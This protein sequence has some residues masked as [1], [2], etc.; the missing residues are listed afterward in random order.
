[1]SANRPD[2]SDANVFAG[3]ERIRDAYRDAGVARQYVHN[4]FEQPLGRLL[5]RRQVRTI[6]ELLAARRPHDVLEIA[7]GPARVTADV[8]AAWPAGG[9]IVDASAQMLEEARRRLAS[10]AGRW[11]LIQGDAFNLPLEARF[12]FAYS[13]RLIRHF[14]DEDR[15]RLYAQIGRVITPGGLFVFD[16]VNAVAAESIRRRARPGAYRHYDALL[17]RRALVAELDAAGFDLV[18]LHG[19]QHRFSWMYPV[20]V[21]VAP[22]APRLATTAMALIDQCGG[23]PLEWIVVCRRR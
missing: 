4:R 11:R 1:M 12:D 21:L 16:A 3:P 23:E 22:R 9:T 13:F 15:A 19:V 17:D 7:P 20:Q 6:T 10:F 18:A 2:L 14:G 8:A 5:H